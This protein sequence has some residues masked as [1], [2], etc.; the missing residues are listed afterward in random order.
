MRPCW[1]VQ[2]V[3][4]VRLVKLLRC[5]LVVAVGVRLAVA[6]LT[7]FRGHLR[8]LRGS[9]YQSLLFRCASPLRVTNTAQHSRRCNLAYRIPK[10]PLRVSPGLPPGR[11]FRRCTI[12]PY[13]AAVLSLGSGQPKESPLFTRS[14]HAIDA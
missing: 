1:Y 2:L 11:G 6:G 13:R 4:C 12:A 5:T 9:L 10:M 7:G 14:G 3:C 8:T